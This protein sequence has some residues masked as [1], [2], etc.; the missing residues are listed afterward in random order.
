MY[1]SS[2]KYRSSYEN[3]SAVNI[4][5]YSA[6]SYDKKSIPIE[7]IQHQN[8]NAVKEYISNDCQRTSQRLVHLQD[9]LNVHYNHFPY[10]CPKC[11]KAMSNKESY[12]SDCK[13]CKGDTL[14]CNICDKI[15]SSSLALNDHKSS[16]YSG[17][18]YLCA[19]GSSLKGNLA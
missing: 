19:C 11:K 6:K 3:H 5:S 14:I 18:I 7:H 2:T 1:W 15:C 4:W 16:E 8:E 10:T 9:H 12:N 17:E 13:E